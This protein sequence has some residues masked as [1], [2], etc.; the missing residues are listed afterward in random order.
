M[1]VAKQCLVGRPEL[2]D[3]QLTVGG[4]N[5]QLEAEEWPD[6]RVPDELQPTISEMQHAQTGWAAHDDIRRQH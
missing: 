5:R 3:D 2:H 6:F 1:S 4:P